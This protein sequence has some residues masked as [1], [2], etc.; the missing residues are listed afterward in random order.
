MIILL[1]NYLYLYFKYIFIV[2]HLIVFKWDFIYDVV[3]EYY[4]MKMAGTGAT[5]P[6]T[7]GAQGVLETSLPVSN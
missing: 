2:I 1:I 3:F 6:S 7:L 4:N 5:F